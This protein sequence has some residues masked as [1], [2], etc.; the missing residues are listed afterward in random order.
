[1]EPPKL[2][3]HTPRRQ[4]GFA[5]GNWLSHL[6]CYRRCLEAAPRPDACLVMEDDAGL[7]PGFLQ[8]LPCVLRRLDDAVGRGWHALRVGC[9][10]SRFAEDCIRS[11][12]LFFA[13]SHPFNAS[14]EALA[15]GGPLAGASVLFAYSSTWPSQGDELSDFSVVCGTA[16]RAGTRVVTTDRK[17]CSVEGL[18]EF[19]LLH[20]LEGPNTET[21]GVS[22]G[23][24][25]EVVRSQRRE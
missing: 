12:N 16:L 5:I 11:P 24:V 19:A 3:Q 14:A 1:M 20:S 13:Q 2:R 15:P 21:G 25:H 23:F 6:S 22:V 10:G 17:L 4:R 7:A 9:W 8:A 18:W